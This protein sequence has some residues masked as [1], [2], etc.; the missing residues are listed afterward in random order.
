[1]IQWPWLTA[2]SYV[3]QKDGEKEEQEEGGGEA[4]R[5]TRGEDEEAAG[6]ATR[7]PAGWRQHSAPRIPNTVPAPISDAG[8][9]HEE[10][11]AGPLDV[12]P[13]V[14]QHLLEIGH[15]E[16]HPEGAGHC[17]HYW[18]QK[19]APMHGEGLPPH[20]DDLRLLLEE[21]R[22]QVFV[23]HVLDLDDE[24]EGKPVQNEVGEAGGGREPPAS[25]PEQEE[26]GDGL[27]EKK[28]A[29]YRLHQLREACQP[30]C[31]LVQ[32]VLLRIMSHLHMRR[33]IVR[34]GDHDE[35]SGPIETLPDLVEDGGRPHK[36]NGEQEIWL[37]QRELANVLLDLII[38]TIEV[39][40]QEELWCFT[41]MLTVYSQ[42]R[43]GIHVV[44]V[45]T[46]N[47]SDG[48][49]RLGAHQRFHLDHKKHLKTD[50]EHDHGS[51]Y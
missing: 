15:V 46:V 35:T 49:H 41:P 21:T 16:T 3:R 36:Q 8:H 23:Q 43:L 9:L 4:G 19:S 51:C 24:S 37:R 31:P 5:A 11:V 29:D 13:V 26:R 12:P 38:Q 18:D 27:D 20:A 48:M 14:R 10:G 39:I 42:I 44:L 34:L 22:Q 33:R 2:S 30:G 47:F 45:L 1:M 32:A 7:G 40:R 50:R 17:P 28:Q 6:G 25:D